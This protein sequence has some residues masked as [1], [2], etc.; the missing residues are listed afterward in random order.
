[1][2]LYI[3][4]ILFLYIIYLIAHPLSGVVGTLFIAVSVLIINLIALTGVI[5]FAKTGKIMEGFNFGAII[6]TITHIGWIHYILSLIVFFCLVYFLCFVIISPTLFLGEVGTQL[7]MFV[8]V[9]L[10]NPL[11]YLE[12]PEI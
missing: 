1:M 5:R 8:S 11:F 9:A 3:I 12:T 6:V 7:W 2:R 10:L 4:L